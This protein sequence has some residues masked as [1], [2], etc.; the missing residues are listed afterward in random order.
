MA[1]GVKEM[2][3][4]C[5]KD[6]CGSVI[7]FSVSEIEKD[8]RLKCGACGNEYVFN[9]DLITKIRKFE[10]LI[11]AVKDAEDILGNTNVGIS[12]KG[13]TVKVPYRLL[14]TRLNT[15]LTLKI[16]AEEL[17]FHFRVEPLKE[18]NYTTIK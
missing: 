1:A 2:E 5:V 18:E 9:A 10:N 12:V 6:K 17:V 4:Q 8:R 14:L 7:S 13:H 16:G 15:S 11:K 3:F